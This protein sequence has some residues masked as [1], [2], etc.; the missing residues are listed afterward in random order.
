MKNKIKLQ[1]LNTNISLA[2]HQLLSLTKIQSQGCYFSIRQKSIK[3]IR[4]M[5]TS[6]ITLEKHNGSFQY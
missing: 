3:L 4:G 5:P 6:A 2:I 1:N